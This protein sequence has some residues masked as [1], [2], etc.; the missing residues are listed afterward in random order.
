MLHVGL[1]GITLVYALR[2]KCS[3]FL[4]VAPMARIRMN[5][6]YALLIVAVALLAMLCAQGGAGAGA[7]PV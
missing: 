7:G 6:Q 5:L 3:I 2:L 4:C 1:R